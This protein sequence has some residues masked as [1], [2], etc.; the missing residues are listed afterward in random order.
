MHFSR[1]LEQCITRPLSNLASMVNKGI[2]LD[3]DGY[4]AAANTL[5]TTAWE[6]LKFVKLK[7]VRFR[8][9]P[10][11]EKVSLL[12]PTLHALL[13]RSQGK[14]V[15]Q[16]SLAS[17]LKKWKK[18]D[19]L[20]YSDHALDIAAFTLRCVIAQLIHHKTSERTV[21]KNFRRTCQTLFDKVA[22]DFAAS[23]NCEGEAVDSQEVSAELDNASAETVESS[24]S[25]GAYSARVLSAE[26]PELQQ[27]LVGVP[28]GTP[29]KKAP[30]SMDGLRKLAAGSSETFA[31]PGAFLELNKQIK[32]KEKAEASRQIK[33]KPASRRV[34]TDAAKM[35]KRKHSQAW[36]AEYHFCMK[37]L[38]LSEEEAKAR[39]KEAG[40]KATEDCKKEQAQGE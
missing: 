13:D 38:A 23:E 40:R 39:A 3:H 27:L 30:L 8:R 7:S 18:D 4:V 34:E 2:D 15:R 9:A 14:Q 32:A 6:N 16:K 37:K 12:A 33:K 22:F 28:E 19:K 17:A 29:T 26:D 10:Q 20:P 5:P 21:P 31:C 24:E 25:G 36:H 11:W 35:L 1:L